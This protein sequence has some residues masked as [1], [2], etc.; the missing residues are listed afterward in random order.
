MTIMKSNTHRNILFSAA[1]TGFSFFM[2]CWVIHWHALCGR[3]YKMTS[4]ICITQEN[5]QEKDTC[6]LYTSKQ[7]VPG[8]PQ[9]NIVTHVHVV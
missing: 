6:G 3:V 4:H 8:H 5:C 2:K 1:C 9:P 7:K